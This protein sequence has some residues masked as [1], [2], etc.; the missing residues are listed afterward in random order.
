MGRRVLALLLLL[1]ATGCARSGEPSAPTPEPEPHSLPP[2][3][4]PANPE[5]PPSQQPGT[6]VKAQP[7]DGGEAKDLFRLPERENR[8]SLSP[9]GR[10]LFAGKCEPCDDQRLYRPQVMDLTTGALVAGEQVQQSPQVSGRIT[11]SGRGFWIAPL[12]HFGVDGRLEKDES[13]QNRLVPQDWELIAAEVSADNRR[14]VAVI[15]RDVPTGGEAERLDLVI[16][17]TP[18]GEPLRLAQAI[19]AE[20]TERGYKVDLLWSPTAEELVVCAVDCHLI[21]LDS[22]QP[23][24]WTKLP[25]GPT[26][27]S[28]AWSLDSRHLL[29]QGLGVVDQTATLVL[30][31][32]QYSA[33]WNQSGSGVLIPDGEVTEL[34]LDGA[35][36]VHP[37]KLSPWVLGWLPDGSVV[38]GEYQ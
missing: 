18:E 34:F 16:S 20:P 13:L 21:H 8:L 17:L 31:V 28:P 23:S 27:Q 14:A 25:L 32:P 4:T 38:T 15:R 37:V 6:L 3:V 11:W 26:R 9:D 10:F 7:L 5:P 33:T 24:S 1:L 12:T 2:A 30:A 36:K 19:A 22:P 29:V 35:K